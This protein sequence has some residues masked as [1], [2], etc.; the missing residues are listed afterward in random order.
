M[1]QA[2][3]F[4]E[5]CVLGDP[6]FMHGVEIYNQINRKYSN[7]ANARAEAFAK[8]HHLLSIAG[9]DFHHIETAATGL[10]GVYLP[11]T[12]NTP[13]EFVKYAKENPVKSI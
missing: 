4:R 9:T 6:H 1:Y 5:Y 13:M 11:E 10:S 3:P 12:I 7:V 2:H 8:E